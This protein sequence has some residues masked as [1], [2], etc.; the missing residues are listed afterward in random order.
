MSDRGPT[1]SRTDVGHTEE[2]KKK[3]KI[4]D[5]RKNPITKF[6]P[7]RS[8]DGKR[9]KKGT[10]PRFHPWAQDLPYAPG[11]VREYDREARAN[12]WSVTG[13]LPLYAD[14]IPP[15]PTKT[16]TKE[17]EQKKPTTKGEK[18]HQKERR[19]YPDIEGIDRL[20]ENEN[21]SERKRKEKDE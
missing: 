21:E 17:P 6:H 16:R 19:P 15:R 7:Q 12:H 14:T 18:P 8:D 11:D 3:K 13:I 10:K 4:K 2:I 5:K 9:R 1:E 20:H